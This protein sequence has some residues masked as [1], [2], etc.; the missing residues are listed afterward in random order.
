M[1]CIGL[2][3][4]MIQPTQ[5]GSLAV[6]GIVNGS[7]IVPPPTTSHAVDLPTDAASTLY[8]DGL[9]DEMTKRE[10]AHIFRGFEG[11]QVFLLVHLPIKTSLPLCPAPV[12]SKYSSYI[13]GL[14]IGDL[15]ELSHPEWPVVDQLLMLMVG[16]IQTPVLC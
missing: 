15:N 16:A 2:G 6:G 13:C 5:G 9:P 1:K 8:V 11:Y 12:T 10:L 4:A 7:G 3:V 14:D